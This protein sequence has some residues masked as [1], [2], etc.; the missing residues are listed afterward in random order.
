MHMGLIYSIEL[1]SYLLA[2]LFEKPNVCSYTEIE[3]KLQAKTSI[4]DY[5]L[6]VTPM[7]LHLVET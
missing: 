3:I 1:D 2:K 7:Q 5:L 6:Y 4:C